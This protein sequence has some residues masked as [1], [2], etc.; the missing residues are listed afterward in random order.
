[1]FLIKFIRLSLYSSLVRI[2]F[3]LQLRRMK[4]SGTCSVC[5]LSFKIHLS[6]GTIHKHGPKAKPCEGSGLPPGDVDS[7]STCVSGHTSQSS[8]IH[9]QAQANSQPTVTS[10]HPGVIS[11]EHP[12]TSR[13]QVKR[14]PK[15][16]RLACCEHL[17]KLIDAIIATPNN[18]QHWNH[19]FN[20]AP[21]ILTKPVRGG[22]SH[23]LSSIITHRVNA[24][25]GDGEISQSRS[26][27]QFSSKPRKRRSSDAVLASA[28]TSKLD[29]GNLKAAIRLIS[30][31]ERP[32]EVS[33]SSFAALQEKHPPAP[34]DRRNPVDPLNVQ[35]NTLQV[36]TIAVEGALKS[37]PPGSSGGPDGLTAQH[38]RDLLG[39]SAGPRLLSSL[40]SLVN[41][42]LRGDLCPVVNA[43]LFGGRLIAL[44]KK[45]GGVRPIAI[46]YT[47]RRLAAKCANFF[48]VNK[49]LSLLL[50][51]QVGVGVPGGAE[52]AVHAFRRFVSNMPDG[53]VAVKIDFSNAF[54]TIRRDLIL[55]SI[56]TEVPE[57]YRFVYAAYANPSQLKFGD[58]IIFSCEGAQQGDPLGPFEFCLGIL[59][60]LRNLTAD[61][62]VS[63]MDDLTIGGPADQVSAA[64]NYIQDK[65]PVYGLRLN[66]SKCGIFGKAS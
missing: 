37:F 43:I 8:A 52:A 19:L 40:T 18:V 30:S 44:R 7:A 46:G 58:R 63:F 14:V 48:A 27:G 56:L 34:T 25:S 17:N 9:S 55:E 53:H 59:P 66:V 5:G 22:K 12:V 29:D 57:I 62:S 51:L 21:I 4:D 41:L 26:A 32:I 13:A 3:P 65:A 49:V 60:L 15:A 24:W 54:N 38:I 50:P 1:M 11:C 20:F 2:L 47:L 42:L 61:F 6:S 31:D 39:C 36:E 23:N 16:A 64:L 45:D 33:D 10:D 35:C 28:V